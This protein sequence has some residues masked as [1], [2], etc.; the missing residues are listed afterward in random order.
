M[1][2]NHVIYEAMDIL[3]KN[4]IPYEREG[5]ELLYWEGITAEE[6]VN[7]YRSFQIRLAKENA[8]EIL[9]PKR[10]KISK[11]TRKEV[12]FKY[13]GRC[14]YCGKSV[15]F[16]EM[17]IDHMYPISMGGEDSY[18]NYMPACHDCNCFKSAMTVEGFRDRLMAIQSQMNKNPL[19]RLGVAHG[20]I[21]NKPNHV[22]FFFERN[23]I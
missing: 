8:R 22:T 14:A 3:E 12:W 17:E 9:R 21:E 16:D 2:D 10:K 15:P 18:K 13:N 23:K 5:V 11:A 4:G 7:A 1:F 6:L 19:Y 20:L